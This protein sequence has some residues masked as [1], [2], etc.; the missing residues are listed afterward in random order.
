QQ[1]FDGTGMSVLIVEDTRV[2]AIVLGRFLSKK[3]FSHQLAVNGLEALE[4]VKQQ[5]F[6]FVLIDNH[7]PI[8]DGI[9]ATE[10]II[11]LELESKPV[12]I[13]C[14]ADAFEE[15]RQKMLAVGC[16]EVI[17]KPISSAKL[18]EVFYL[19]QRTSAS[20][21]EQGALG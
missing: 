15:T 2:N 9:K 11:K 4:M 7:M 5:H 3:G 6:D 18:D 21:R 16:A 8:M 10:A 1:E 20:S 12:I 13:G 14:T 19:T 17:T